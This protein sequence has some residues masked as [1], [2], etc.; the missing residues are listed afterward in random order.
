MGLSN[1]DSESIAE[2]CNN[3]DEDDKKTEMNPRDQLASARAGIFCACISFFWF[4]LLFYICI[5]K[6]RKTPRK[7]RKQTDRKAYRSNFEPKGKYRSTG[8]QASQADSNCASSK[9][10]LFCITHLYFDN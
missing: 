2:I 5:N 4:L 10:A 6:H 3:S 1:S 8:I 7:K 9:T